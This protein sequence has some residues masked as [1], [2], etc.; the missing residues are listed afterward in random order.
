MSLVHIVLCCFATIASVRAKCSGLPEGF[1]NLSDLDSSILIDIRYGGSH[2][3]IGRKIDGYDESVCI[4]TRKA[5]ESL[6]A[7]H[8][9]FVS[10]IP[11]YRIKVYDCYRPQRAVKHFIRWS[12]D[13]NDTVNKQEFYSTLHKPDLFS[14]GYVAW[15]SNHSKGSSVDI[16]IVPPVVNHGDD[17]EASYWPGQPLYPCYFPLPFRLDDGSLDMGTAFDCFHT[18]SH[19]TSHL[20]SHK[21]LKRRQMLNLVMKRHGFYNYPLEWWHFS[22]LDEPFPDTYFD[23]PVTCGNNI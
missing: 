11:P 23:F 12:E 10:A 6:V 17:V 4:L 21:H 7:A 5:A 2:N 9:D 16:T 22:V 3:F 1:V 18:A 14:R 19:T 8:R 15:R 20:V 13:D